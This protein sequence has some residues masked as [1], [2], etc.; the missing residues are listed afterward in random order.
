MEPEMQMSRGHKIVNLIAVPLPLVGLAAA[1][2]LLWHK[3]VGPVDLIVMGV[4]YVITALGITLGYHRMFT[5]RAFES[6]AAFR[7]V[8]AAAG[9]MAVQGSVI[10]W[11]A[12]H[13][14]HHAFTDQDGDPHTPHGFGPGFKGAVQGLWH[15]HVGWLFETVGTAERERFVPDLLKDRTLRAMDKLFIV[16]VVL[17]LAIPFALGWIIGGT[18]WAALIGL[19]WGGLVRIFLLH[20]VTWSIN[21]VCHFFGRKRFEVEDESRNVFWLAPFSMGEAWHHNHHAFPTSAFHGLSWSERLADP[22]G[23]LIA[24]LEKMG[25]IWNVVRISPERQAAKLIASAKSAASAATSGAR[26]LPA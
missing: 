6:S 15:A 2:V 11:V 10:T 9:S 13:R 4:L 20:H 14:K 21:S 16:F 25:L 17:G 26:N 23:W 5:H 3:A 8:V 22:T 18:L 19:L 7:A 24:A 1:V 12:D